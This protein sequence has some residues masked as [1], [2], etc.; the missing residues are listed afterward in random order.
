M[1][2]NWATSLP[3]ALAII[4]FLQIIS[5][6]PPPVKKNLNISKNSDEIFEI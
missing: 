4:K 5:S 3:Q 1:P 6:I 2:T